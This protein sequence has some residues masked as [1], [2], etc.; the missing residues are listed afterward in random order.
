MVASIRRYDAI[1]NER[2][3]ELVKKAGAAEQRRSSNRCDAEVGGSAPLFAGGHVDVEP[4]EGRPPS[5][6]DLENDDDTFRYCLS[7]LDQ[8]GMKAAYTF[9]YAV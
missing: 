4:V 5:T 6:I 3:D 2:A 9:L 7:E 1:D 8:N